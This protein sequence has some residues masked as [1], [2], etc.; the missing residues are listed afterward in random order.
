M[1]KVMEYNTAAFINWL[2]THE[3]LLLKSGNWFF[4]K[5]V[6]N[7]CINTFSINKVN[8]PFMKDYVVELI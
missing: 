3:K 4:I 1:Q 6:M 5:N 8:K 2:K 7:T